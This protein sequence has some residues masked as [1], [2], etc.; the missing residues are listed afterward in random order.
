MTIIALDLLTSIF[1]TSC[2]SDILGSFILHNVTRPKDWCLIKSDSDFYSLLK[3]TAYVRLMQFLISQNLLIRYANTHTLISPSK[4]AK[5]DNAIAGTS[6]VSTR[7]IFLF[8][9]NFI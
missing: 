2:S 6:G 7:H 8:N 1:H 9:N 4:R 3:R 5:K